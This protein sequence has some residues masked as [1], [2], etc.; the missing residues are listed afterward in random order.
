MRTLSGQSVLWFTGILSVLHFPEHTAATN[1]AAKQ[2]QHPHTKLIVMFTVAGHLIMHPYSTLHTI[3]T[4]QYIR[5][6]VSHLHCEVMLSVSLPEFTKPLLLSLLARV[7]SSFVSW[8]SVPWFC[9]LKIV[10]WS[11]DLCLFIDK[12][13][14]EHFWTCLQVFVIKHLTCICIHLQ[15]VSWQLQ[16]KLH[17]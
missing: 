10:C 9:P 6:S 8:L 16:D 4:M 13:F 3:T 7:W 15:P 11:P 1:M 12:V 5:T 17:F 2:L 14:A